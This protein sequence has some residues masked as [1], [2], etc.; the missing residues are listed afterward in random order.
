MHFTMQ[1][2]PSFHS[3]QT[4]SLKGNFWEAGFGLPWLFLG[5]AF[6]RHTQNLPQ[7]GLASVPRVAI[8]LSDQARRNE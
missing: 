6:I 3:S 7:D 1:F 2:L 4:L 8:S 5:S